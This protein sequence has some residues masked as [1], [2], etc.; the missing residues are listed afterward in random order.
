MSK[1]ITNYGKLC[2]NLVMLITFNGN[3]DTND[4]RYNTGFSFCYNYNY[5]YYYLE[6]YVF[7]EPVSLTD[8]TFIIYQ[9]VI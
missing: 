4:C 3:S 8:I 9:V 7:E 1:T 6:T 2:T 5:Y